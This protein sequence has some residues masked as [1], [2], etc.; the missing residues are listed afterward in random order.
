MSYR[1]KSHLIVVKLT[2]VSCF[3]I[4]AHKSQLYA[5]SSNDRTA[6][7]ETMLNNRQNFVPQSIGNHEE[8]RSE[9]LSKLH[10]LGS[11]RRRE[12]MTATRAVEG[13]ASTRHLSARQASEERSTPNSECEKF[14]A[15]RSSSSSTAPMILLHDTNS[16][17]AATAAA[18][19]A[20]SSSCPRESEREREAGRISRTEL[21]SSV[22]ENGRRAGQ[23]TGENWER[24]S[25]RRQTYHETHTERGSRVLRAAMRPERLLVSGTTASE[26]ETAAAGCRAEPSRAES[27]RRSGLTMR[28]YEGYGEGL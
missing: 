2:Q 26:H 22:A 6:K 3:T 21:I 7:F 13:S 23:T 19:A 8:W 11:R 25:Q 15:Q 27:S 1:T 10:A 28:R 4:R 17:D 20:S 18:A 12:T 16:T 9:L 5:D 24:Q 14:A